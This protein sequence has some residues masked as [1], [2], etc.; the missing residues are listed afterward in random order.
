MEEV[1]T[2]TPATVTATETEVK[3][4]EAPTKVVADVKMTE[5]DGGFSARKVVLAIAATDSD[6]LT[7]KRARPM[8]EIPMVEIPKAVPPPK[9]KQKQKMMKKEDEDV[10]FICFD[11]GSLVLCDRRWVMNEI[12][13][14]RV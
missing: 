1:K 14:V 10:C 5:R 8:V 9:Q 3:V 4:V 12:A 13:I 11:G 2:E 6:V 7:K